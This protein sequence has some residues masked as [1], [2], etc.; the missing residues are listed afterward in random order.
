LTVGLL[1]AVALAQAP[2]A[3]PAESSP[4]VVYLADGSS[5]PLS[6][7]TLTY[8]FV[9]W[10]QG[11]T[12][13]MGTVG[14]REAGELWL[15]KRRLP[16][17]GATL[18]VVRAPGAFPRLALV[19][20]GGRRSEHKLEA[21]ARELLQVERDRVLIARS[22]DLHGRTLTGTRRDFCLV[23]YSATVECGGDPAHRVTRVEFPPGEGVR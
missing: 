13:E 8:E 6:D 7:W 2:A 19:S 11:S 15:G 16:V 12:P 18:E 20:G 4:A 5:L 22:L 23:S 14:R 3:E 17:A 10:P 9:A 1:L 21:P